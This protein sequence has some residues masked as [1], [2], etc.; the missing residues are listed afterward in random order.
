M[1]AWKR[2][3]ECIDEGL[4][5]RVVW[6]KGHTS[7]EEKAKMTPENQQVAWANA[8]TDELAKP[9][10]VQDGA[11]MAERVA[12]ETPDT[13]RRCMRL[14]GTPPPFTMRWKSW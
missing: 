9:G 5:I 14:S 4:N 11:E 6:A 10:A 8:K 12:K 2:V 3:G 1:L 7:L 13:R